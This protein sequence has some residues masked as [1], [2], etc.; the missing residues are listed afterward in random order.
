[1]F[2]PNMTNLLKQIQEQV[3]QQLYFLKT[4]LMTKLCGSPHQEIQRALC[5]EARKTKQHAG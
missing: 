1:H 3:V 5:Q 2:T 4:T